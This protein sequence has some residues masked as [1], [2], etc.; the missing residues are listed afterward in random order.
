[1]G[2]SRKERGSLR[3]DTVVI[4]VIANQIQKVE[5]EAL[6]KIGAIDVGIR[7]AIK[8]SENNQL[9]LKIL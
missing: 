7:F 6:S 3:S 4:D 5:N 2:T 8:C 9:A 1:M